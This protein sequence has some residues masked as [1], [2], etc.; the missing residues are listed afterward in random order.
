MEY[1]TIKENG[2]VKSVILPIKAFQA[3]F[4]PLEAEEDLSAIREAKAEPLY[5]Q[6]EAEDYISMNPVK[7][8]RLEKGW[9]QEQLARRVGV[10]QAAVANMGAAW[11]C[12]P[13]KNQRKALF[14]IWST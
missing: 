10:T 3:L 12:L 4:N 5:D 7:R 2:Q 9:T 6:D 14:C 11:G 1:Q 13:K 8:E